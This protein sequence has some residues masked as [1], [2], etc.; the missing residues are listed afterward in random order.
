MLTIKYTKKYRYCVILDN[1]DIVTENG[2][3]TFS[4]AK[5]P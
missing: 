3:T 2:K 5:N 4:T 1:I